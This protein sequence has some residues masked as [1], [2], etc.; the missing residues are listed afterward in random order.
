M[1]GIFSLFAFLILRKISILIKANFNSIFLFSFYALSLVLMIYLIILIY[2]RLKQIHHTMAVIL[3][4]VDSS[5]NLS[6]CYR[7]L[8]NLLI[9][10][11]LFFCA[12][13]FPFAIFAFNMPIWM[14]MVP[15][16]LI[17]VSF[18]YMKKLLMYTEG[19]SGFVPSYIANRQVF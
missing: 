12:M 9:A 11:V 6:K 3:T 5:R 17:G 16:V 1:L 2:K 4:N 10:L 18:Y 7:I 19:H 14:N 15:F 8:N 13:L